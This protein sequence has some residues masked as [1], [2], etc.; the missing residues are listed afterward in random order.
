MSKVKLTIDGIEV[1]A[2]SSDTIL[3]ASKKAGIEIPTLC[4]LKD[5]CQDGACRVCVVEV[6]GKANLVTSCNNKVADGMVVETNNSR[7]LKAR[8]TNIELLLSNH[9]KQCL[10]CGKNLKCKLQKLS[11]DF[12]CDQ[13]KV[14]GQ[15]EP[16]L[17][18]SSP[19]IIRDNSKC[20][21]CGRCINMCKNIQGTS[22]IAKQYRGYSTVVGCQFDK[23]ITESTCVGCGQCV[24]VCPTGALLETS[25]IAKVANFMLD[26]QNIVIAQV[27]PAV[28]VAL[29]E[30]F[31][32][33]MGDFVEGKM[34]T[35]L[36]RCGFNKVFDVNVGADLTV[37]EESAELLDRLQ[38]GKNLPL[39]T[40]CCPA[41]KKYLSI[42]YPNYVS[43]LSSCKSPN[44]MLGAVIK[45]YYAKTN[46][47]NPEKI[48]VVAVM[49]CTAKKHEIINNKDVDAVLTTRELAV[50]I[51]MKNI[52]FNML[53][54]S[55]FDNPLGHY[56]GAGLIF[57]VTGG[58]TEAA[59]R[60]VADK[61]TNGKGDVDFKTVRQSNGVKEIKLQ[62][63]DKKLNICVVNG[64]KNAETV[65][66]QIVKG[67]K[68]YDFVEV[69]ACPGGCVNGGGQP[70]VDYTK[71]DYYDVA[72]LRA[73]GLYKHDQKLQ[74]RKSHYNTQVMELYEKFLVPDGLNKKLLHHHHED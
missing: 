68:Q 54:D 58:V 43:N 31:G 61:L 72:K 48:K 19:C 8:K 21:L 51:K 71:T 38:T 49:P 10:T 17:D 65:L 9:N 23:P 69:M 12:G 30:E 36:K 29:G 42:H 63:S 22:A 35:A 62:V 53:E 14:G 37:L 73:K 5:V 26:P 6:K 4:Y 67:K 16:K 47:I 18:L 7:V 3:E 74:E 2:D 70:F 34:V 66:E 50:L 56:S 60:T 32:C 41:W 45:S 46:N 44:E 57:G 55:S 24:L 40:S 64:L 25:N 33:Q 27:A 59:L 11:Y 1:V 13:S 15:I 28:R 39:F 20:I 52:N